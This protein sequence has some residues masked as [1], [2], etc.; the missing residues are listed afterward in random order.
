MWNNI[1]GNKEIHWVQ[2]SQHGYVPPVAYEGRDIVRE[3]K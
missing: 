3:A 2:G 1:P